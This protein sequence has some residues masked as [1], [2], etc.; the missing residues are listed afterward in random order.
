M[1]RGGAVAQI[2]AV[3]VAAGLR[4]QGLGAQLLRWAIE[5]ARSRG[6]WRV[7]LTTNKLRKD[8]HRFYKRLGFQ[9]THEGMKLPL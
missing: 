6:C 3:R 1:H 2:E 8:A 9:D 7:Q 4:G 5:E